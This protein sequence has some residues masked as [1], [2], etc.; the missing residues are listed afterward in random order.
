MFLFLLILAAISF[1]VMLLYP[2][3][4]TGIAFAVILVATMID[5]FFGGKEPEINQERAKEILKRKEAIFSDMNALKT[6]LNTCGSIDNRRIEKYDKWCKDFFTPQKIRKLLPE[7]MKSIPDYNKR[8]LES[9]RVLKEETK[10]A[11]Q[12]SKFKA[13]GNRFDK[14]GKGYFYAIIDM[15][16]EN[17]VFNGT[18]DFTWCRKHIMQRYGGDTKTADGTD[19]LREFVD[20]SDFVEFVDLLKS[21]ENRPSMQEFREKREKCLKIIEQIEEELKT[22]SRKGRGKL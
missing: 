12:E 6:V 2:S 1:S 11:F 15:D 4:L 9:Y 7:L 5:I 8:T 13:M 21:Q 17:T 16:M 10:L 20:S 14:F 3:L 18:V 22:K 19:S